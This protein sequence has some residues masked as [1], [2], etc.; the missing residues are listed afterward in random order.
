MRTHAC[1]VSDASRAAAQA[2]A[3]PAHANATHRDA[4]HAAAPRRHGGASAQ[5][6]PAPRYDT[7]RVFVLSASW[8]AARAANAAAIC[9]ALRPGRCR[10]TPALRAAE[11]TAADK[12]ALEAEG[13]VSRAPLPQPPLWSAALQAV[14]P[15]AAWPLLPEY[16]VNQLTAAHRPGALANTVGAA[17]II[18]AMAAAAGAAGA[19]AAS[20][21]LYVYLEDD[22][23]LGA[24]AAAFE[25]R[26]LELSQRLPQGWHALSL[27]PEAR[28]CARSARLPWYDAASGLVTPRLAFSRTTAVVYSAEGVATLAAALPADDVID[29]W[30]RRLMRQ[31]RLRLLLHCGG[32]VRVADTHDKPARKA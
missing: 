19:G 25:P 1:S 15:R 28:T 21:T 24:D 30:M 27:A 31:R 13:L 22:A 14:L 23:S 16:P 8:D 26:L 3:A 7:V 11:L 10:V 18:R 6:S 29:L 5:P 2:A 32:L 17:R 12:A 20:R 4:S 9:G